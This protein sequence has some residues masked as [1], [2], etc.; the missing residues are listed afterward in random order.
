MNYYLKRLSMLLCCGCVIAGSIPAFAID[1]SATTENISYVE[2]PENRDITVSDDDNVVFIR[3][4][5]SCS[6]AEQDSSYSE[7]S[8][9][10]SSAITQA[11][12][13][14]SNNI[15]WSC[16]GSRI[17][18]QTGAKPYGKTA[19]MKGSTVQSQYHYT[20]TYFGKKKY[21]ISKRVWDYEWAEATGSLC[22]KD[23]A[24]YNTL[25]VKY[26]ITDD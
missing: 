15:H 1:N 23:I 11:A 21:G 20:V 26:G 12:S 17:W 19:L 6:D 3:E 2:I 22:N 14:S 4:D 9:S 5:V 18:Y 10:N 25:Y 13:S 7:E 24:N 16:Q 8:D